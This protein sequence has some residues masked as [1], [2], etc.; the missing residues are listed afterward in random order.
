MKIV[1]IKHEDTKP[2]HRYMRKSRVATSHTHN[3]KY[4]GAYIED[5]LVGVVGYFV[6]NGVARYKYSIV[7]PNYRGQG[8][9]RKLFEYRDS[10]VDCSVTT[11]YCTENSLPMFLKSGFMKVTEKRGITFVR[12]VK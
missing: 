3:T 2:L 6:N 1:E 4:I 7:H 8:I 5:I 12:R 9:Y 10:V 11:A